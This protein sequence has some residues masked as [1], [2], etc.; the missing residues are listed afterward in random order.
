MNSILRWFTTFTSTTV[1]VGTKLRQTGILLAIT[2]VAI[3]LAISLFADP[4]CTVPGV[5]TVTDATGDASDA[6][7][8]HDI[9]S[10]SVAYPFT[11]TSAPDTLTFTIK[12]GSLSTL[13]PGSIYF[14][15]FTIDGAAEAAGNVHGVRMVVDQ[16]GT[17]AFQ[18]YT[19]SAANSGAVD[20]RFAGSFVAAEAG[21]GYTADGT[22]T[23]IARPS[24][25]G[26]PSTGTHQLTNWNGAVAITAQSVVTGIFDGMPSTGGTCPNCTIGRGGDPFTVLSNQTCNASA[27]PTPTP[28]ATPTGKCGP[29]YEQVQD[30]AASTRPDPTGEYSIESVSFGEPFNSCTSKRL[31]VVMKV[32]SMDPQ[33][34]GTAQPLPNAEWD[35]FFQIPGSANST[36]APQTVFVSFD[37]G[38][39]GPSGGFNY[40]WVDNTDGFNVTQNDHAGV[41]TGSIASDGTITMSFNLSSTVNFGPPT[42]GTAAPWTISPSQWTP[43][44]QINLIQGQSSVFIGA[45]IAG[46]SQPM[47][48]TAGDGVYTVAGNLSCSAPPVAALSATPASGPAPLTVNFDATLSTPG[49]CGTINAYI[50]DFGDGSPQVNQATPTIAHTYNTGGATYHARVRVTNTSGLTS[51]NIAQQDITVNPSGPPILT[52]IVSRKTHGGAGD[53]DI[54]LPQPPNARNVECRS[55]GATNDYKL[56]F[57]FLNNVTSVGSA[58]V[59]GGAGSVPGNIGSVGPGSNQYT[60]NL[61]GV[62]SGQSTTVTLTNALDSTGALGPETAIIGVLIGDVNANAVMTNADVSLVKAQV[63]AGGGVSPS[64]FRNDVNANGVITNADVSVTKAQVAAG[65]SLP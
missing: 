23:I 57:T 43:G 63:A 6:Q 26:V 48:T 41:V 24:R 17:P 28:T 62:T 33:G 42:G 64:N 19:P 45:V 22:I 1:S 38:F 5:T 55:G 60:V 65:A 35:V 31:T 29:P 4:S 18:T 44:T 27:T 61:T 53:F 2:A 34:N 37:T 10:T 54:P 39:S 49:Q 3:G 25:V 56:I 20:G 11:T 51:S 8:I 47:A 52:S 21:S 36:G 59:T 50:F 32:Q 46:S 13:T 16:S 40:G 9:I 14:T 12:V 58:T 30:A 15:T 7:A